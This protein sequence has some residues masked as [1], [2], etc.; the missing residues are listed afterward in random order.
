MSV[1]PLA[2]LPVI[3][4]LLC[5]P[6]DVDAQ[7]REYGFDQLVSVGIQQQPEV[8]DTPGKRVLVSMAENGVVWVAR[9]DDESGPRNEA[10]LSQFYSGFI[11][12]YER[13]V[14]I[15]MDSVGSAMIGKLR[16]VR[17]RTGKF[18]NGT[19]KEGIVVRLEK[20]VYIFQF[21][22]SPPDKLAEAECDHF[23]SSIT[24][25]PLALEVEDQFFNSSAH[26][27]TGLI[28]GLT[29]ILI[30]IGGI[31]FLGYLLIRFIKKKRSY[32]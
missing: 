8:S 12:D 24:F 31:I 22:Y 7:W 16:C 30:P 26:H 13:S 6:I 23:F 20:K 29:L 3:F 18:N 27:K 14:G 5:K 1:R 15:K 21:M 2:Y 19:I 10:Q 4:A 9:I 32:V 28:M 17:Y 25:M 11:L